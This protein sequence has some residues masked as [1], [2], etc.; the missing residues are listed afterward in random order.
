MVINNYW[1]IGVLN[2]T[3]QLIINYKIDKCISLIIFI[4]YCY[5]AFY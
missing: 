2:G 5:D 4:T 1:Q 3:K